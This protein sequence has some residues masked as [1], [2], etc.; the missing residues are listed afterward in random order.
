MDRFWRDRF[1]SCVLISYSSVVDD[2]NATP[3]GVCALYRMLVHGAA[4][5]CV[6]MSNNG[7]GG[8]EANTGFE[9]NRVVKQGGA[10][11]SDT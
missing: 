2:Y 11:N 5:C 10:V 7:V 9:A 8:A 1:F 6:S 4:F 3:L